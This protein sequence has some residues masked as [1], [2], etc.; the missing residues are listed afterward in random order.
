M[1]RVVE[2][3]SKKSAAEV[4]PAICAGSIAY[5]TGVFDLYL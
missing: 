5:Y 4:K 3:A 1:R 2:G